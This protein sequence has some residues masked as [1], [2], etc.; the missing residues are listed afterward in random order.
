MIILCRNIY[1]YVVNSKESMKFENKIFFTEL[2][3]ALDELKYN[4]DVAFLSIV[5]LNAEEEFLKFEILNYICLKHEKYASKLI[6]LVSVFKSITD[7]KITSSIF[8]LCKKFGEKNPNLFIEAITEL[9]QNSRCIDMIPSLLEE[10]S[11]YIPLPDIITSILQLP[12]KTLESNRKLNIGLIKKFVVNWMKKMK[13][14]EAKLTE[15]LEKGEEELKNI[16]NEDYSLDQMK[17][18]RNNYEKMINYASNP[19]NSNINANGNIPKRPFSTIPISDKV[20]IESNDLTR[21]TKMPEHF[22]EKISDGALIHGLDTDDPNVKKF[23]SID[24][25]KMIGEFDQM[26]EL[27]N[28]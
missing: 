26:Y 28:Q 3:E 10:S 21:G 19:Q 6:H 9:I 22:L 4:I 7:D 20:K 15:E 24:K 17:E 11:K 25:N 13:E 27:L 18:I 16:P 1:K 2:K 12:S 5:D 23:F 14:Y 8:T